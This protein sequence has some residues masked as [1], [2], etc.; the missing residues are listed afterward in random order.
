MTSP[1]PRPALARITTHSLPRMRTHARARALRAFPPRRRRWTTSRAVATVAAAAVVAVV[2]AARARPGA[3]HSGDWIAS[4]AARIGNDCIYDM[5]Y[6]FVVANVVVVVVVTFVVLVELPGHVTYVGEM[7]TIAWTRPVESH[8]TA[9]SPGG[10]Y[11][12]GCRYSASWSLR[13]PRT[14][15]IWRLGPVGLVRYQLT[16]PDGVVCAVLDISG[17]SGQTLR[18][19][20]R[21]SCMRRTCCRTIVCRHR[22]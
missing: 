12:D 22:R 20:W 16:D 3:R 4:R 19:R 5:I 6:A 11:S 10:E 21:I 18:D 1:A 8:R 13:G 17:S 9:S 14:V 15:A 2:T 7:R